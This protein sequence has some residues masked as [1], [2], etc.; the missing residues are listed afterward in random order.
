MKYEWRH[1]YFKIYLT[2]MT[3]IC[4]CNIFHPVTSFF[5]NTIVT[6]LSDF[7]SIKFL[8]FLLRKKFELIFFGLRWCDFLIGHEWRLLCIIFSTQKC[9]V[10][11]DN[12]LDFRITNGLRTT[13]LNV[14]PRTWK[15]LLALLFGD[16]ISKWTLSKIIMIFDIICQRKT[17]ARDC[18][19]G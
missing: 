12:F 16:G 5:C 4:F 13:N 17:K 11:L 15:P 8:S 10:I 9:F 2:L 1:A 3:C 18:Q 19:Q 6:T 14:Y 7:N